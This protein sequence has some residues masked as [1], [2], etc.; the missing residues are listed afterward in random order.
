MYLTLSL[1]A[2]VIVTLLVVSKIA[3]ML[4]AKRAGLESIIFASV[5]S[6]LI[7]VTT[8]IGLNLF[9]EGLD[10]MVMLGVTFGAMLLFSSAAFKYINKMSWGAAIATNVANVVVILATSVAAIVLNGESLSKTISSITHSARSNTAMVGS[11]VGDAANTNFEAA[12][13]NIPEEDVVEDSETEPMITELDLLPKG[14]I[15]AIEKKKKHVY[16]APKFHVVSIDSIGSLVGKSL[17]IQKKNGNSVTGY[18]QSIKGNDAVLN[19]RISGGTAITPI[20]FS[21]I[22]KLE[23]YR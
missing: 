12:R 10:P 18:L 17:R 14:A 5:I 7:A 8:Y 2:A 1:L 16:V 4:L 6:A 9:V 20:S 13:M 22:K 21:S 11:M 23:V 15:K 3:K 19:Q